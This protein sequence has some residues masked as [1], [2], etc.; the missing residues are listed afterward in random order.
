MKFCVFLYE[1]MEPIDLATF[2]VLSIARRV[3]PSIAITTVAP[4]AGAVTLANGLK[5]LA[6]H[7]IAAPPDFDVLIVGGG[8]GWTAQAEDPA[9]LAFLKASAARAK[10]VSVCTG[11]MILAAAGL[12]DG[13]RAT[14]KNEVLASE[15]APLQMLHERHPAVE[16]IQASVVD[17]GG[18]VTGGGVTLCI[19]TILHVLRTRIGEQVAAE[20][21][22]TIEY[23]HAWKA[24][25]AVLPQG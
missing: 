24:N 19:D 16:T 22:R 4:A 7:G 6:D 25:Q 11:G 15:T 23:A 12:L 13:K 21:A 8:P 10:L 2:G 17:E 3:D 14:T 9:T 20:T 1:G 5:V 18:V